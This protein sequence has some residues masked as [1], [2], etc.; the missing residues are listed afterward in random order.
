M[1]FLNGQNRMAIGAWLILG[2]VTAL[3]FKI[4]ATPIFASDCVVKFTYT[5]MII[6]I[7]NMYASTFEPGIRDRIER[8]RRANR[9]NRP[10]SA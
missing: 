5:G 2:V 4:L 7:T 8:M 9:R 3:S 10:F 1:P 6:P